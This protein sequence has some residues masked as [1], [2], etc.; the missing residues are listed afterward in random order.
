V[1]AGL[2]S[3]PR[4]ATVSSGPSHTALGRETILVYRDRLIPRSEL[5]F[6]RRLYVGFERLNPLW[7]GRSRDDGLA[8]LGAPALFLGREGPFGRIDREL[9]KHFGVLPAVPDLRSAHPKLVHAHFGR[10]GALALPMARALKIPLVVSFYGADA[11]KDKQYQGFPPTI[12]KRRLPALWKQA[13]LFFCVSGFIKEQ[14]LARGFPAEKLLVQHS[15]VNIDPEYGLDGAANGGY[16]MFA[17]RFVEKKGV[18]SLIEA[19]RRLQDEGRERRLVLVGEGPMEDELRR[20]AASL[21]QVEFRGWMPNDEL[22]RW[23]RGALALCVPSQRASDGDAEGL[24]TVVIEAM[25]AGTPVIGSRHAGIGE[26]V[27][28]GQTGFLIPEQDP[29]ALAAALRRLT[30]QPELRRQLGENARRAAVANFEMVAQSRRLEER[31]LTV[32]ATTNQG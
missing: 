5:H 18:P 32:M 1:P 11:T 16:V 13:A 2:T 6:L 28:D 23:M 31:L 3:P 9:F 8:D 10:G 14:L 19:M 17:G 30:D 26:A 25:A 24:P 15:G 29:E 7:V 20:A 21:R 12:F 22:R 4:P 27:E